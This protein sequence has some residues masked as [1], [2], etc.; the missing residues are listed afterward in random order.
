[1]AVG[2]S[3]RFANRSQSEFPLDQRTRG[4]VDHIQSEEEAFGDSIADMYTISINSESDPGS[5]SIFRWGISPVSLFF[6]IGLNQV[7]AD[8]FG[9]RG[10][11]HDHLGLET[12]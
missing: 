7:E 5:S 9:W 10:S 8:F 11:G 2:P 3:G 4:S 12:S 1:M 6:I